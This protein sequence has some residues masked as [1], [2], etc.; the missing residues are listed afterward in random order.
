MLPSLLCFGH[1]VRLPNSSVARH[2]G[3]AA[4][5]LGDREKA[6]AYYRQALEGCAKIR[7]HPEAALTYPQVAE[8]LLKESEELEGEKALTDSVRRDAMEHLNFAILEF[9]AMKIKPALERT[10]SHKEFLKVRGTTMRK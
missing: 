8:L 6:K 1:G 10:L 4:A 7:I 9:Q 2:L 5:L 3:A